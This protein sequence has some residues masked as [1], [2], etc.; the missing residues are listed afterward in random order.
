MYGWEILYFNICNYESVTFVCF[1]QCHMI[2]WIKHYLC[3]TNTVFLSVNKKNLE[4]FQNIYRKQITQ[5]LDFYWPKTDSEGSKKQQFV[6]YT[7]SRDAL[8]L[9]V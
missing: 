9:L 6:E 7:K 1:F 5:T 2:I 3:H 4:I 8:A